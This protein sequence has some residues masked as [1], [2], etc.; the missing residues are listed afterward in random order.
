MSDRDK[1]CSN[2]LS[3][4]ATNKRRYSGTKERTEIIFMVGKK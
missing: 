4:C 3:Q 1:L 2:E